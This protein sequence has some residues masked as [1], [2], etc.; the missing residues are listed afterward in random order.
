MEDKHNRDKQPL[1][2]P[3]IPHGE[4]RQGSG[5]GNSGNQQPRRILLS[6][7]VFLGLIIAT[8]F[9]L[10]GGAQTQKTEQLDELGFRKLVEE[11]KVDKCEIVR[12][13]SGITYI[14]G[15]R[16]DDTKARF[17]VNVLLTENLQQFLLTNSVSA[18]VVNASNFWARILMEIFPIILFLGLLYFIF[19]RQVRSAGTGAMNFGK[20]RARML[21]QDK[22][23]MT[24]SNVAGIREA[25]EEVQE[26]VEFLKAPQKFQK[27][28]GRIPKGVLLMGPPGTGK[29]LLAKAIAGEANVPFFSISGS[30]FV[31]MFVGVGAS[32]VRDMFEQGKK[33]APCLIFIDEI[34]AVGR[35]RFSGIGGGH[36]EREQTLNALLVEMDGFDTADGVIIIAATNRSDVLDPALL[37]PGRFDRQIVIDLPDIDGREEILKLHADKLK[38][39]EDTDLRR[40]ARGTPGFSGADLSNLLNEAALLAARLNKEAVGQDDMEEARDKVLWGRERR[41]RAMNDDE[42]RITAWHESGHALVQVMLEHTEPL[43]KVTII[44]R[45]MALGATM[46][47]PE[48]DILNKTRNNLLDELVV[49]MGGRIAEKM[50][51]GDLSTGA[52]MDLAMASKIARRMVCEY[53]MSDN[54]GA[55][56]FG[57]N[58]E[59]LFLGREVSRT[60]Q[61]SEE[62]AQKIDAEVTRLLQ[63]AFNRA[64]ALLTANRNKLDML[65][66]Y[67]LEKETMDGR[68]VEDLVKFGRILTRDERDAMKEKSDKTG[69][70]KQTVISLDKEF[71]ASETDEVSQRKPL[72]EGLGVS[73]HNDLDGADSGAA[74]EG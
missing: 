28:G 13:A 74:G 67:L 52:R 70:A 17:R 3:E 26:I 65:V 48:R 45:G 40:V 14:R 5:K 57:D 37:R 31:E 34:D 12:E 59:L 25:K 49:L 10:N 63:G 33:H 73:S 55:Q 43:H 16:K 32:R 4:P 22:Q 15:A 8:F 46:T 62:T 35:S 58:Q 42:R 2:P 41:S 24:F 66:E 61:Y 44:P 9:M 39:A 51:T 11:G 7:V 30:D 71:S 1:T 68:D 6:W 72:P 20:S 50:Y 29:T 27:L 19:M 18:S 64:E 36:D 47:L 38:L 21:N 56:A 54:I 53:G 60:Q 23:K 69:E